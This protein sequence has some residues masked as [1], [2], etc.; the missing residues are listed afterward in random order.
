[1][2]DVGLQIQTREP[3]KSL[4]AA[5]NF[6]EL[7]WLEMTKEIIKNMQS[8]KMNIIQHAAEASDRKYS[9]VSPLII[10]NIF[11]LNC[12]LITHSFH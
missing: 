7:P 12:N 9:D 3:I 2:A 8:N 1:M 5:S 10:F 6:T 11:I 4:R